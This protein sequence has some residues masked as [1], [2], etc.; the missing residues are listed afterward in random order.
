[1]PSSAD[2]KWNIDFHDEFEFDEL[3][4][5]VQD[6]LLARTKLLEQFG[7]RLSR[8]HV[9]TLNGSSF[10][11]MKE[12]RFKLGEGVWRFAFAFDTQ[13]NGIILVGGDKQ[14]VSQTKFYKRL[15]RIADRRYSDHLKSLKAKKATRKE[16]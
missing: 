4:E 5:E 13:Q 15:I 10:A 2:K 14:G 11:N 16:A 9:D 8:P 3:P 7:P 6:E 12:L 1:M